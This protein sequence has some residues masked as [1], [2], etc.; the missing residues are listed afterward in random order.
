MGTKTITMF[1][2][3]HWTHKGRITV[4]ASNIDSVSELTFVNGVLAV[5]LRGTPHQLTLGNFPYR[6]KVINAAF[7]CVVGKAAHAIDVFNGTSN[8]ANLML[9]RIP[10]IATR[11]Q[12]AP[13]S[14]FHA[15]TIIER[16]GQLRL[17]VS[18]ASHSILR[19][20]LIVWLM[21]A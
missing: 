12:T 19:G 8:A 2:N 18:G 6:A 3:E 4:N 15:N 14:V 9:K 13:V 17:T 5:Q 10:V 21:P 16:G 20:T 7:Q 11:N 1:K